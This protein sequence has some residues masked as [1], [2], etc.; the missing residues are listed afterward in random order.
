V[1]DAE[2]VELYQKARCLFFPSLYEGFG[3]PVLEGLACG[4]PIGASNTSSIPEVAGDLALY[5]APY[6][7]A[8]M[9]D[10]LYQTLQQPRDLASRNYRHERARQFSWTRTAVATVEAWRKAMQEISLG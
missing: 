4:L 8:D 10:V 2:L 5:F 9:A 7:V 6:D 1:T 3:L